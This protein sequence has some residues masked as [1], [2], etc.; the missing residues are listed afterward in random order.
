MPRRTLIAALASAAVAAPLLAAAP[1]GAAGLPATQRALARGMAGIGAGGALV[2]DLD[3]RATLFA[4]RPDTVRV[5]ASVEKL[6]TT[7]TALKRFGAAMRLQTR[8]FADTPPDEEGTV[9]GN[10]YLQGGGDPD[11]ASGDLRRLAAKVRAAG[12]R[13]ITGRVLGDESG[14]DSL[15]GGPASNYNVSAYVGPLGA[16]V[17]D[18]G[19]TGR[20]SP[21][22]QAAPARFAAQVLVRSLRRRGIDVRAAV[23]TGATPISATPVTAWAS[24]PMASLVAGTLLPS[25]NYA[26][27]TLLKD[28]GAHFGDGG[29][30]AAGAAVVRTALAPLQ[31]APRVAD[32]S[33]LSRSNKTSP[34]QVVGLLQAM[35]RDTA[36]QDGLPV[37][38]RTGTLRLRMRG[39]AAQ[40]ACRAKT[41]TLASVSALAGYCTTRGGTDVAFAIL[42][43]GV[44]PYTA[45]R[46]Q[47]GMLAALARYSAPLV[48][49][50][51]D[52]PTSAASGGTPSPPPA[53]G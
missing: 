38:G 9:S 29:S 39:S 8:V 40:D 48:A 34:R 49:E 15:R 41:G 10:L 4:A 24:D 30:T 26:A 6:Y 43:N 42:M 25:D 36:F 21:Y 5:P 14:F 53:A 35:D 20:S 46:R 12:V 16:L 37:A 50:P 3:S 22:W 27:E 18:H 28:L 19:R 47:D 44:S 2:V 31:I 17:V 52:V 11:L 33:G 32:G 23:G 51:V 1:A 7:S 13:R 45:Q